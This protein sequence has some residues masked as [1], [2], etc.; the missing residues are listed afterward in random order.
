MNGRSRVLAL[1][2][3]MALVSLGVG[4]ICIYS[5]YKSAFEE[6]RQH[7]IEMAQS[8][9]RLINAVLS[10]DSRE[11]LKKDDPENLQTALE[12]LREARQEFP[13]VDISEEF[14]VA[15]L[16]GDQILFWGRRGEIAGEAPL[17]TL[18]FSSDFAE[19]M[20]LA[21]SGRSGSIVAADYRGEKVLAAYEPILKFQLG[22]VVK[23]DL[24][25]IRKP[26]RNA[27]FLGFPAGAV[28][29]L[30]GTLWFFRV[31]GPILQGLRESEDKYRRFFEAETDA[32]FIID[33]ATKGIHDVNPSASKLFGYSQDEFR[34]MKMTDISAEP[35]KTATSIESVAFGRVTQIFTRF[36]RKKDGTL[37]PVEIVAGAFLWKGKKLIFGALRDITAR[38][39]AEE[40]ILRLSQAMEQTASMVMITN[41]EGNIE[42][43]NSS[44]CGV[45]GYGREEV[46][47]ENPRFLKSGAQS[48]FFYENLWQDLR[49]GKV[50]QGEFQN[51]KKDGRLFWVKSTI[52]PVR[53]SQGDVTHFMAIKEDI[54]R[55]KIYEEALRTSEERLV[56]VVDSTHGWVWEMDGEGLYTYSNEAVKGILGYAPGEIVGKKYFYDFFDPGEMEVLKEQA[57]KVV[58]QR[59]GFQGFLN[60]NV[61]KNGRRVVLS[62][63]ASPMWDSRGQLIG[64][65]GVDVDVTDRMQAEEALRQSEIKFRSLVDQ[66]ADALY[67]HGVDGR[68]IDVN[69]AACEISGYSREELLRMNIADIDHHVGKEEIEMILNQVRPGRPQIVLSE[70]RRK[71]G[72]AY[73]VEIHVGQIEIAG[74]NLLLGMVRDISDRKRAEETIQRAQKDLF[75]S[76]K[77]VSIGKLAAG[78][79]HEVLNPLNVISLHLQLLLRKRKDDPA[80]QA[81]LAKMKNETARIEKIARSLLLFSRQ[82]GAELSPTDVNHELQSVLNILQKEMSLENIRVELEF[83]DETPFTVIDKD[84]LRQVLF[85]LVNNARHAMP[86]G[87]VLKL[88]TR[89]FKS[90]NHENIRIQIADTGTGIKKENLSKIFEPFFTTKPEGVGTGMGLPV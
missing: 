24:Y 51:R 70:H 46:I 43:V 7:L 45:T 21:L 30:V 15:Q 58:H 73:P 78:V 86:R 80:L 13:G 5:L 66:A 72:T 1:I 69:R 41:L 11:N 49:A 79:C 12:T 61:H 56:Q 62:T 85:N 37:F 84:E 40:Q 90:N 9:A 48:R 77:L 74:K 28:L 27:V 71:D 47:G 65:R 57:F 4:G 32:V 38:F 44:F 39:K 22:I 19:L 87:G 67:M 36:Y 25:N 6:E 75:S 76:E 54:T 63:S 53:N 82:G 20:R 33:P 50:W 64:Y 16:S 31:I 42:Y 81:T 68:F 17:F 2:F 35:E 18:P 23:E 8:Q 60:A 59:E 34:R 10:T 14:V 83:D 52:T 3:I 55:Q 29:I 88:T 26:F 89:K